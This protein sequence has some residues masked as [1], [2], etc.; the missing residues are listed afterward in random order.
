[1]GGCALTL[2]EVFVPEGGWGLRI[3]TQTGS[4]D[5]LRCWLVFRKYGPDPGFQHTSWKRLSV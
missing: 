3:R 2:R 5:S 1:M 4:S